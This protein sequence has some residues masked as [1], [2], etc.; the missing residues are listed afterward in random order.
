MERA[1]KVNAVKPVICTK[2]GL[3]NPDEVKTCR[4]CGHKLQS[5]WQG[6]AQEDGVSALD[7]LDPLDGPGLGVRTRTRRHV[8]AWILAVLFG[9]GTFGLVQA[10]A[11][12]AV[13]PLAVLIGAWAWMRGMRWKE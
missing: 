11:V 6:I 8:E 5:G 7:K 10:Q 9:V 13:A 2:C 4:A 12:W 1:E 3:E